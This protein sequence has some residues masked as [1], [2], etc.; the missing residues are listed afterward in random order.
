MALKKEIILNNGTQTSYHKISSINLTTREN[1]NMLMIVVDSF[2]NEEYRE[3]NF[4][5]QSN[6]YMFEIATDEDVGISIR[7][8]GYKK[9][10]TL[11]T[12][13]NAEDC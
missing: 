12:F 7:K 11:E 10:K 13:S 9:L 2:M 4:P 3:K 6:N 8:L 5:I 1:E